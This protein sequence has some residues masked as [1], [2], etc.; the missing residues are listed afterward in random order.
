M[1]KSISENSLIR[2]KIKA[3]TASL[4]T[5][6]RRAV[7]ALDGDDKADDAV[8]GIGPAPPPPSSDAMRRS[9]ADKR[10][11]EVPEGGYD[12][13]M[14]V[15]SLTPDID[16]FCDSCKSAVMVVR[17]DFSQCTVAQ[18]VS[19]VEEA[20]A[21]ASGGKDS[22]RVFKTIALANHGPPHTAVCNDAW[23]VLAGVGCNMETGD[24]HEGIHE[25]FRAMA[26]AA[27]ERIDLL[28]CSLS[29]TLAGMELVEYLETEYNI[30][31]TASE[32]VNTAAETDCIDV[33]DLY[34]HAADLDL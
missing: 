10:R 22:E 3:L 18:L 23:G 20:R 12:H 15:S 9:L 14:L 26:S 16:D 19:M 31:F 29:K 34:F 28:A 1:N 24:A 33:Q 6:S 8:V 17:Y 21:S 25:I 2:I 13:L 11:G 30:N 5:L 7:E 32:T 4:D 27:A